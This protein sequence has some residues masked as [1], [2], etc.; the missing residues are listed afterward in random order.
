MH[1]QKGKD[2]TLAQEAPAVLQLQ[3]QK[4]IKPLVPISHLVLPAG[5]P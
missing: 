3:Y 4:K 1:G 2:K 5:M